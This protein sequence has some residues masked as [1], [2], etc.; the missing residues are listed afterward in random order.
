M[1]ARRRRRKRRVDALST[2]HCLRQTR[3]VCARERSDEAIHR[4]VMPRY[5]FL[6]YARNGGKRE[7]LPSLLPLWEKVDRRRESGGETDEG[8]VSA[9]RTPHPALRATFSHKGRREEHRRIRTRRCVTRCVTARRANHSKPVQPS[10]EKYSASRSTQINPTTS[11]IPRPQ[12]GRIAIVTDVGSGER[13]P[14]QRRARNRSLQGE[15]A[16]E[17]R[18]RADDGD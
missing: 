5:G 2:R 9:E 11:A 12:E 15:L 3:S 8:S 13:W 16:H 4:S 1:Q 6:R 18:P 17:R 7:M 14:R 10:C